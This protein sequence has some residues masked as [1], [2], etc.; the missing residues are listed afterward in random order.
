MLKNRKFI[1]IILLVIDIVFT[2]FAIKGEAHFSKGR[3]QDQLF[4]QIFRYFVLFGPA[5][6]HY[7]PGGTR[8]NLKETKKY[9]IPLFIFL[10][11]NVLIPI[12]S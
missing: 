2:Y 5:I 11:I 4:L 9:T 10:I 8:E 1:F 6:V 3:S 7:I 12:Y